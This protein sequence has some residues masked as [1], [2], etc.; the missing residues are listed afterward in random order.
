[1]HTPPHYVLTGGPCAGKTTTIDELAR[2]G[3]PVLAEAARLVIE[4]GLAAG[5]TLDEIRTDAFFHRVI[6]RASAME[7]AVPHDEQFFFD[8]GVPDSLAYYK[9]FNKPVDQVL[10]DAV[11]NTSYRKIFLLDLL[12]FET[13]EA[14]NETPEQAARIHAL[15]REAYL[16]LGYEVVEVPVM[17]VEQRVDFIISNL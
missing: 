1:M 2:R 3:H 6:H 12:D 11:A 9:L 7:T 10:R 5:K 8:R 17:P 13:D 16:D 4:E 15:I 14:R